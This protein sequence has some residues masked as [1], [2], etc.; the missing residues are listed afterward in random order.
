VQN[1]LNK[2]VFV[3]GGGTAEPDL[4]TGDFVNV[5]VFADAWYNTNLKAVQ[6]EGTPPVRIAPLSS[7]DRRRMLSNSI[8]DTGTNALF[9]APDVLNAIG[10]GLNKLNPDF[11]KTIQAAAQ[12][13]DGIASSGLALDKWPGI[14]FILTGDNNQEVKLTCV[15]ATYWQVDT[16]REGQAV[17]QIIGNNERQSILGLPLMNNYYTVFDRTMDR[18]GIVRFAPIKQPN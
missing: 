1:P 8:V 5:K 13:R 14:S 3:L 6:V 9:L 15:P 2:G 12:S 17:F 4:Y 10:D 16:P 11:M 7:T 18:T